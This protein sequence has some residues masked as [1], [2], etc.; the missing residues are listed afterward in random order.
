[1]NLERLAYKAF[2]NIY[3]GGSKRG[4]WSPLHPTRRVVQIPVRT[5]VSMAYESQRLDSYTNQMPVHLT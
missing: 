2:C 3:Y 5:F 4:S 1:M